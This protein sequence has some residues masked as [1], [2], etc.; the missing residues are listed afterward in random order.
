LV[1]LG[2]KAGDVITLIK[3]GILIPRF[4]AFDKG[5][6]AYHFSESEIKALIKTKLD[7]KIDNC[8]SVNEYARITNSDPDSIRFL[9]NRGFINSYNS[10]N[11][12]IGMVL[13]S[14]S[15]T[16]FESKYI[17]LGEIMKRLRSSGG[18]I[19]K[20]LE[21]ASVKPISGPNIDNGIAYVYLRKDLEGINFD[22]KIR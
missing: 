1:I 18:Y 17:Y 21:N 16:D 11:T 12:H 8:I 19:R 14:K 3:N 13:T 5:L 22:I 4:K 9:I 10:G 20:H 7:A 2:I 6:N 15:I